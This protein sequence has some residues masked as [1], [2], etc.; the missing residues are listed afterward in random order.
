MTHFEGED[1]FKIGPCSM[2]FRPIDLATVMGIPN[3]G[4]P[5]NLKA[6]GTKA[7]LRRILGIKQMMDRHNVL[8]KLTEYVPQE[9]ELAVE[10]SVKLWFALLCSYFF[11]PTSGRSGL[12]S[13]LPYLDDLHEMKSANW[14]AAI[15]EYLMSGV[16]AFVAGASATK[17]N[18]LVGCVPA[19]GV[20]LEVNER[21]EQ[22]T[23]SRR[24]TASP[25]RTSRT[26]S[27]DMHGMLKE[28]LRVSKEQRMIMELQ[29]DQLQLQNNILQSMDQRLHS[30]DQSC[31][32]TVGGTDPAPLRCGSELDDGLETS[33]SLSPVGVGVSLASHW[34][35]RE[36]PQSRANQNHKYESSKSYQQFIEQLSRI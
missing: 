1:H 31:Y 12:L 19:L 16:K 30:T 28:L 15:H 3:T 8:R 22:P 35:S 27:S 9:G 36:L 10:S 18:F 20:Y 32:Y 34:L 11:F 33:S 29:N 13:I 26:H 7:G 17:T 14:A 6:D 21:D 4:S 2:P 24:L 25:S 23:S 5:I